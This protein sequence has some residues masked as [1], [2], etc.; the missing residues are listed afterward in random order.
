M[1]NLQFSLLDTDLISIPYYNHLL[2]SME[3]WDQMGKVDKVLLFQVGV[4][5]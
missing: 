2:K 3:F 5:V 4:R 1:L